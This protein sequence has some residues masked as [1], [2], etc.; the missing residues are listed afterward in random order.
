M[1]TEQAKT[2]KS[3]SEKMLD[4]MHENPTVARAFAGDSDSHPNHEKHD[5]LPDGYEA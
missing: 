5:Y 2:E 3:P 4:L 1:S